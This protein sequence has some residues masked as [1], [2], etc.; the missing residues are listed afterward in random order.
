MGVR[1]VVDLNVEGT[2]YTL[3]M[4]QTV[5]IPATLA[6]FELT[7]ADADVLMVYIK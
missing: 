4:G 1:G 7:A 6:I 5:L 2:S 3:S